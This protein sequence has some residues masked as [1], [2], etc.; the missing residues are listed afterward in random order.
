MPGGRGDARARR[1]V[2]ATPHDVALVMPDDVDGSCWKAS[3]RKRRSRPVTC[4]AWRA[5]W[6]S[7][8][9]RQLGHR[10]GQAGRAHAQG[11]LHHRP[12]RHRASLGHH[13]ED[14]LEPF[15]ARRRGVAAGSGRAARR[16]LLPGADG[17]VRDA[18]STST[19]AIAQGVLQN[20]LDLANRIDRGESSQWPV[21]PPRARLRSLA[22]PAPAATAAN[23][24]RRA[25][26]A[27]HPRRRPA[28]RATHRVTS[29]SVSPARSRCTAPQWKLASRHW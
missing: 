19:R 3:I 7:R 14:I 8:R 13:L 10:R 11:R 1:P 15:R 29:C 20:V 16:R 9:G 6:R 27:P 24:P 28:R 21:V 4:V 23:R 2:L 25:A 12:A 26:G 17:R 18:A 22:A 5:T